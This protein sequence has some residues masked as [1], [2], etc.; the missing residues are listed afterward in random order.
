MFTISSVSNQNF[1]VISFL[2]GMVRQAAPYII[3]SGEYPFIVAFQ[4]SR[5]CFAPLGESLFLV[6]T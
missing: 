6:P 3:Y 5:Y 1:Q 4:S 2:L